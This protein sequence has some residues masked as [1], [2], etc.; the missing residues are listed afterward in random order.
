MIYSYFHFCFHSLSSAKQI[1]MCDLKLHHYCFEL[2]HHQ[3]FFLSSY[4]MK[5]DVQVQ[6]TDIF[7]SVMKQK[8]K[9]V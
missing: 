5:S 2:H 6:K 4:L 7:I 3:F 8:L 9:I 1:Q